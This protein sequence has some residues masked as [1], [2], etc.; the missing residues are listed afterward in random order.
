MSFILDVFCKLLR[1]GTQENEAC[2][3]PGW[4]SLLR[5][6]RDEFLHELIAN[7]ATLYRFR[8][9]GQLKR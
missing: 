2:E 6:S 8:G 4:N 1:V 7:A 9:C 5:G 3:L